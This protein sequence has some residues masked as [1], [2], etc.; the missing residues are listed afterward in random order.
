L[1]PSLRPGAPAL[2]IQREAAGNAQSVKK[3][4]ELGKN[5]DV[6]MSADYTLIPSMMV[7]KYVE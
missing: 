3:I 4:T 6:P 1:K 2:K 5:A 7:P